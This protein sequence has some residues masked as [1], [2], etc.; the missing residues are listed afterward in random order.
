MYSGIQKKKEFVGN[1]I[2][3]EHSKGE[4]K[5]K[6]QRLYIPI[7]CDKLINCGFVYYNYISHD[8]KRTFIIFLKYLRDM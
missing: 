6:D 8:N 2:L 4:A 1:F 3:V 5:K 7:G